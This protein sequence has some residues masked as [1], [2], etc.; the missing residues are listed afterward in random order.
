MI[1]E[2]FWPLELN[3]LSGNVPASVSDASD[4]P[5]H[6]SRLLLGAAGTDVGYHYRERIPNAGRIILISNHRSLYD[7]P[8]LMA[9]LNRSVRFACH[10]YMSRVPL[11]REM[12]STMGA[13]PLDAPRQRHR[14][15]FRKSVDLLR[16]KQVVGIFP[17]GAEPMVRWRPPHQ[18]S[19]FHRGFAHLALRASVGD[20]AILPVAIA[21]MKEETRNLAPLQLFRLADPS[22][23]LFDSAGWHY[24]VVYRHVRILFG[25]P[26][27]IDERQRQRYRGRDGGLLAKEI[28]Q[29][30]R[31]QILQLLRQGCP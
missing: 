15:F 25:N 28:T 6:L 2:T 16:A 29:A 21:S 11:L 1:R 31:S 4:V 26:I 7:A 8:L 24:A 30:C 17:E 23:P 3:P 10:Y 19:P 13:F 12:V 27:W 9:A 18:L 14:H 5:L 22:E 20:L